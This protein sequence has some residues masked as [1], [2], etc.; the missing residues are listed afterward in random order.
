M[1]GATPG[2]PLEQLFSGKVLAEVTPNSPQGWTH[3][4]SLPRNQPHTPVL[5][6]LQVLRP[7]AG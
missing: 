1:E 3:P 4:A 6:E 7:A 5:A 2:G